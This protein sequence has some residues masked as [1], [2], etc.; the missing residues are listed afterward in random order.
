MSDH[1]RR[2][3]YLVDKSGKRI[4]EEMPMAVLAPPP[5]AKEIG[6]DG[7]SASENRLATGLATK[8]EP[9]PVT[10]FI[11]PVSAAVLFSGVLLWFI[12]RWRREQARADG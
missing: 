12:R 1:L 5:S 4:S 3:T 2:V 10:R 9:R 6:A 11:L 7:A 8:E